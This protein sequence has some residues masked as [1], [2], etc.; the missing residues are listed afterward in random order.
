VHA[1]GVCA[2]PAQRLPC[3]STRDASRRVTHP[4]AAPTGWRDAEL[5]RFYSPCGSSSTRFFLFATAR[6]RVAYRPD[7]PAARERPPPSL[8]R[9]HQYPAHVATGTAHHP[10]PSARHRASGRAALGALP[11]SPARK[12]CLIHRWSAVGGT[13]SVVYVSLWPPALGG[14]CAPAPSHTDHTRPRLASVVGRWA[15]LP[16]FGGVAQCSVCSVGDALHVCAEPFLLNRASPCTVCSC[17]CSCS[18]R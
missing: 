13:P 6:R 11:Q 3:R 2:R 10:P 16:R 7:C 18:P 15:I 12:V 9:A 1:C 14:R 8:G 5:T 17:S 4:S